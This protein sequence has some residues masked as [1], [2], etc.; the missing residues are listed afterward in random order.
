MRIT[1]TRACKYVQV[2]V[3]THT[4]TSHLD[5]LPE[6]AQDK[7]RSPLH[8][9]LGAYVD[10]VTSNRGGRVEGQGLVLM[11]GEGV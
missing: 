11:D 9:V 5:D 3:H 1:C 7:V 6:E 10:D 8:D 4:H 2:Y